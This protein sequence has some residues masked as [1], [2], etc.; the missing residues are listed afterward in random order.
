M[1]L[2]VLGGTMF[3]VVIFAQASYPPIDAFQV[4]V[5]V[6]VAFRDFSYS[7]PH[8]PPL[9]VGPCAY[10]SPLQLTTA[11]QSMVIPT[12]GYP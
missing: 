1:L 7:E 9:G 5:H 4:H 6:A 10:F 11:L 2:V 3:V 8:F 12:F